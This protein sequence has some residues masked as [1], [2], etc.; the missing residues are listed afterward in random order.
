MKV[1]L[2]GLGGVGSYTAEALARA[3]IGN[4]TIVDGDRVSESNINRQLCALHSTVGE[5]KTDVVE[6]RIKDINPLCNVVKITGFYIPGQSDDIDLTC[7][8]YVVDAIDN[9]SAKLQIAEIC[10]VNGVKL[11]SCMGTGNKLDASLFRISDIYETLVCPLCRV[12]RRELK[13]RGINSLTVLWSPEEPK[14]NPEASGMRIPGS[15]PFVPGCAG[16]QIAGKV[17]L[18][19]IGE[20]S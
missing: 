8:D 11:I 4:I 20:L 6:K 16:L 7:Y 14:V 3:G 5:Y 12:M 15:V 9:V 13:K 17:I 10:F 19:L 1:I 2:F 18:D